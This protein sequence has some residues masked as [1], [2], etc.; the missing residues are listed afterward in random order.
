MHSKHP[1]LSVGINPVT[2][3]LVAEL[4][5]K[6]V[7]E[8]KHVYICVAA[9]HLLMECQSDKDLC[10]GVNNADLVVPDGMPLV[11]L[12]RLAGH[13]YVQR[14]YG[15]ALM[16]TMCQEAAHREWRV[17]LLGGR[18]GQSDELAHNLQRHYHSLRIV[19]TRDTPVR[20]IPEKQNRD[21][22]EEINK[23][24]ADIVFVG[25]GCPEQEL[26]MIR[27]RIKLS[28]PVLMGVGAA[29]DFLSGRIRQAPTWMQQV[30]LEWLFR[31]AREPRRLWRR[32]TLM[33][34]KF[35]FLLLKSF[36]GWIDD[37]SDVV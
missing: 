4:I 32:Y 2:P 35:L 6:S 18:S 37:V 36:F 23:S 21:I 20:P 7:T 19:G 33:N 1:I 27:N 29:F 14:V 9:V 12:L 10:R 22:V 34:A 15:P 11:W 26:W 3:R 16:K 24:Q 31:F 25:I 28:S 17:Y 5:T 13:K 30:G 8:N